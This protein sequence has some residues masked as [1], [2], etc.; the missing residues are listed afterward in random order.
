MLKVC[1]RFPRTWWIC[2][3]IAFELVFPIVLGLSVILNLLPINFDPWAYVISIGLGYLDR[4][5][6]PTKFVID[7]VIL[8]L[9][10]VISNNP[11]TVSL[12]VTSFRFNVFNCP[13]LLI[14]Y[15]PIIYTQSLSHGISSAS[16]AGNWPYFFIWSFCTLA[17]F[18]NNY[19]FLDVVSNAVTVQMLSNR[20]LR[21][22]H[23]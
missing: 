13:C 16:S 15:V 21:S 6:I 20:C 22:I 7:V 10:C 4:H 8:S 23:S 3:N 1:T 17:S 12:I 19:F 2:S 18:T 14:T 11:V 9:Y 5:A